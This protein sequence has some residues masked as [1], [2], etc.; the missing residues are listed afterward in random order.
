M[1][2]SR[3]WLYNNNNNNTNETTK[4][5]LFGANV[6]QLTFN[7]V[8]NAGIEY[9]QCLHWFHF[10]ISK[11]EWVIE[12]FNTY[13]HFQFYPFSIPLYNAEY[14]NEE[15]EL[16]AEG[17]ERIW[18]II[19]LFVNIFQR[20]SLSLFVRVR[21]DII[22]CLNDMISRLIRVFYI[23]NGATSTKP[24]TDISN[25]SSAMANNNINNNSYYDI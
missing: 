13:R 11:F 7:R 5:R 10:T 21:S 18:Y 15:W 17:N 16:G 22:H 12:P 2:Y 19:K 23:L 3:I 8:P 14:R 4:Q 1:T 9:I 20:F 24:I 6:L 25:C